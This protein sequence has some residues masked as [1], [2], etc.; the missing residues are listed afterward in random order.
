MGTKKKV[1]TGPTNRG[2][3]HRFTINFNQYNWHYNMIHVHLCKNNPR[4]MHMDCIHLS[5][6]VIT[7]KVWPKLKIG[8]ISG[9]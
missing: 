6:H 5:V 7:G 2:V 1:I 8:C 9:K 3:I 4:P